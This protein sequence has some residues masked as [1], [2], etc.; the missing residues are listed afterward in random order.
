MLI[1][2]FQFSLK[3]KLNKKRANKNWQM[4][5]C[6]DQRDHSMSRVGLT[7]I[8]VILFNSFLDFYELFEMLLVIA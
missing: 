7:N 6:A 1:N 2:L 5:L 3:V 8:M 4:D